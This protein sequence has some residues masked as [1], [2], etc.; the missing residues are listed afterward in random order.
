MIISRI[1]RSL[2]RSIDNQITL[3]YSTYNKKELVVLGAGWAGFRL[4]KDI[5]LSKY[6]VHLVSPRNHFL[7]TPLLASVASGTL[8]FRSI[9]EPVRRAH[10]ADNY[11]FY[12]AAF[13]DLDTENKMVNINPN[14]PKDPPFQLKYD[15]LV[16]AIGCD[17]NFYGL[18]GVA[19]Y[20]YP[21]KEIHHARAIRS[22]IIEC[23][24]R[25]SNPNTPVQLRRELLHFVIVGAGPTGVETA[26]EIHDLIE[27]DLCKYFPEDIQ[28]DIQMTV[29]EA[30]TH[31]LS[32]FDKSLQEYTQKVF[33]RQRIIIRTGAQV[34]EIKDRNTV[35]LADGSVIRCGLVIWSA[36]IGP[37]KALMQIKDKIPYDAKFK[38]IPVDDFLRVKGL[39]DVFSMGDCAVIESKP[40]AATAQVAQQQGKYLAYL[41]NHIDHANESIDDK[42]NTILKPFFYRHQGLMAYIGRFKAVTELGNLK[43]GGYISWMLWRSAYLTKLVSI[44]NK[45]L[46]PFDWL[47]TLIFGRDIS[48]F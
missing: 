23:F 1:Y 21:M 22:E 12:E 4:I 10:H 8:E 37:R 20:A 3:Y 5:D 44:K 17:V 38:K 32:A 43:H 24:E 35:L 19:E 40:L 45:I 46:V 16:I 25:A 31:V 26:A 7:F 9:I 11:H 13:T 48:R 33:R 14:H 28:L 27:Q 39:S 36:G 34:K 42:N 2:P 18:P 41:L 6:N 47:K 29:L 30:S 15:R